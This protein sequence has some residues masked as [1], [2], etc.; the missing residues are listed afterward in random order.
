M[1]DILIE[2]FKKMDLNPPTTRQIID[3]VQ[4]QLSFK[5]PDDYI[6]F[7]LHANGAE[8]R[9]GNSYMQIWC[10]ENIIPWTKECEINLYIPG[11]LVFGSSGGGMDYAFDYR[12][13]DIKIIEIPDDS[14][15]IEES[16]IYGNN[17]CSFL[18]Y[19]YDH[20]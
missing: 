8:G 13:N 6:E 15:H 5:L 20:E 7:M 17:F 2:F 19:I 14:I 9:F 10:V 3:Y 12:K 16:C 4:A 1:E 18:Q 11:I